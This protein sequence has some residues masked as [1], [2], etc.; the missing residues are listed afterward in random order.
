MSGIKPGLHRF[1]K[2]LR[3]SQVREIHKATMEILERGGVAFEEEEALDLFGRAGAKVQNEV[4]RLPSQMV[5][6][7]ELCNMINRGLRGI[8]VDLES[9]T[10]DVI[11]EVGQWGN[12]L[13]TEHT[14]Q[15]FREELFLPSLFDRRGFDERE[16]EGL[17]ILGK[18]RSKVRGVLTRPCESPIRPETE[19]RMEQIL[20]RAKGAR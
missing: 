10:L 1:F 8:K 9:L 19:E 11:A 14:L 17:E 18:A 20:Q 3:S 6:D 16:G 2:V 12:Y 15:R 7:D 5:I 13:S 4:V